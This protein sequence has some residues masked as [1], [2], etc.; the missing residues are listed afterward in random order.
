MHSVSGYDSMNRTR[1]V[2]YICSIFA[3]LL[4]ATFAIKVSSIS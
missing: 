2:D 1:N 3:V 4:S